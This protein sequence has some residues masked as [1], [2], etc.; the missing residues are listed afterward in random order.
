M[1]YGAGSNHMGGNT[2]QSITGHFFG[3]EWYIVI[4]LLVVIIIML[5]YLIFKKPS[6]D[7]E[8]AKIEKDTV[9]IKETVKELKKKWDEIE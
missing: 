7:I 1:Y 9:E 4:I 5:A 8:L 3:Y 6:S 2:M